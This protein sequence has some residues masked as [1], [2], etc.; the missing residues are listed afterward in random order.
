MEHAEIEHAQYVN[1][2]RVA[3]VEKGHRTPKRCPIP[4]S[5]PLV[6][7][8]GWGHQKQE[9]WVDVSRGDYTVREQ[10]YSLASEDWDRDFDVFLTQYLA[11]NPD[12]VVLADYRDH[13]IK[14]REL[15][16]IDWDADPFEDSEPF[17]D[18]E[19]R[20]TAEVIYAT[21]NE[22]LEAEDLIEG[23]VR[24]VTANVYER[25]PQ[26]RQQ[27]IKFY[28]WNCSACGFN[29]EKAYGLIGRELI[30]VHHLKPLSEVGEEYVVEPIRDLRPV[31]ANCHAIIH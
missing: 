18:E 27:C 16:E 2:V 1:A 29:F 10:R 5:R 6:I 22:V 19:V 14:Q 23:A 9:V 7:L 15:P 17:S 11:A 12:V 30:H 24:Q 8:E 25:S 13:V 20:P 28:G 26:A 31:C 4:S 3:F 21:P